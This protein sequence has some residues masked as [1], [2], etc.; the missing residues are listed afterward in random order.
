MTSLDT[1]FESI[2]GRRADSEASVPGRVNLI[3]EHIDYT[4]GTVLP[5]VIDLELT[6]SMAR[7]G[8][9]V[10]IYSTRF[11]QLIERP[12]DTKPQGDWYDYVLAAH[13][14]AV[15]LGF[16]EGGADFLID[17]SI[18]H[19]AGL[20]S[21]AALIVAVLLAHAESSKASVSRVRI[22]RWAQDVEREDIGVPCG[23]M[24]QM[25]VAVGKREHA[26]A[27]DTT[28]CSFQHIPIPEDM[29]FPVFHSGITRGLVDGQYKA[30]FNAIL[31][32]KAYFGEENLSLI[33]SRDVEEASGLSDLI[34]GRI[35]HVV[36]EHQRS[37]RAIEALTTND[38][39]SFGRLMNESHRSMRDDFEIVPETIDEMVRFAVER[40]AYGARLTGGGFGG[41]FVS[42]VARESLPE[43]RALMQ[44]RFPQIMAI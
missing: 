22:A 12:L 44:Q 9:L 3:G 6:V 17:S 7:G 18:P 41:C 15:L 31:T 37:L 34:R 21:S 10:R 23:I 36:S 30:R 35:R 2:F 26:L 43:W 1:E 19:G 8:D 33:D 29:V 32:G 40:G 25:A 42:C 5:T 13:R 27:L 39:L 4:G 14:R 24:D 11:D 16:A 20:S 38:P 28:D